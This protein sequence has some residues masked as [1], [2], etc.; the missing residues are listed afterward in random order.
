M[1]IKVTAC[2]CYSVLASIA[3][4]IRMIAS[5]SWKLARKY[6]EGREDNKRAGEGSKEE[7]YCW[8][9]LS[10]KIRKR[11]YGEKTQE[12][13]RAG[14]KIVELPEADDSNEEGVQLESIE[15]DMPSTLEWEDIFQKI[16]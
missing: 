10:G 8:E 12:D 15:R 11:K 4:M 14:G 16:Q 6:G 3:G 5:Y 2:A 7:S 9:D 13:E 1:C